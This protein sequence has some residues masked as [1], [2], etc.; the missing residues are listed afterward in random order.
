MRP[1]YIYVCVVD[2]WK[3]LHKVILAH[4]YSSVSFS[5]VFFLLFHP[6][7]MSLP[8]STV[9]RTV[10]V[11]IILFE[12]LFH[13]IYLFY[14]VFAISFSLSLSLP[15]PPLLL[16]IIG[17]FDSLPLCLAYIERERERWEKKWTKFKYFFYVSFLNDSQ[18]SVE[19]SRVDHFHILY[20]QKKRFNLY[21]SASGKPPE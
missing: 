2:K 5:A 12:V 8:I 15:P 1:K 21:S 14:G 3:W 16:T 20:R 13:L 6:S 18:K 10:W 17:L 11:S 19:S 9:K 4:V 7:T